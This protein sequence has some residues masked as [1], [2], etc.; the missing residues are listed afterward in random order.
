MRTFKLY[1]TEHGNQNVPMHNKGVLIGQFTSME[2]VNGKIAE[3]VNTYKGVQNFDTQE[4]RLGSN[5][6]ETTYLLD[7][8]ATIQEKIVIIENVLVVQH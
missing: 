7:T 5:E 6:K 4:I 8:R 1:E 2:G 3:I